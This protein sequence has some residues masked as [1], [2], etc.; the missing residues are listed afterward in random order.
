M[1]LLIREADSGGYSLTS[2]H[3]IPSAERLHHLRAD[4]AWALPLGKSPEA[5][6]TLIAR[7]MTGPIRQVH[8]YERRR[9]STEMLVAPPVLGFQPFEIGQVLLPA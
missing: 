1:Q 8:T 7:S 5:G 9:G 6:R 2:P 3:D 4:P